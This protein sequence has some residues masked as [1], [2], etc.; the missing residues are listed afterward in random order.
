MEEEVG[1]ELGSIVHHVLKYREGLHSEIN[2][3]DSVDSE[4]TVESQSA[5][6][7]AAHPKGVIFEKTKQEDLLE[8]VPVT[9]EGDEPLWT[10][11]L[12]CCAI[13]LES[14]QVDPRT[15]M[16]LVTDA[17]GLLT[18]RYEELY[19]LYVHDLLPRLRC[20]R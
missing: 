11:Q 2:M 17:E 5:Y 8:C 20:I 10:R 16:I 4:L 15:T 6:R 14:V 9:N 13:C 12:G 7:P 18:T 1:T 3:M 19:S